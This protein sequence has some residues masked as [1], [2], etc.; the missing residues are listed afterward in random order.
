ML[1]IEGF[2]NKTKLDELNQVLDQVKFIPG[3]RSGGNAGVLI[4]NNLQHDP[5]DPNYPRAAGLVF[6]AI[7]A[8]PAFHAYSFANKLTPVIF[9][10]YSPGMTYGDHVDSAIHPLSNLVVR[11]DLSMT[12]FLAEPDTYDG[13]ELVINVMGAEKTVKGK[14]GD[15]FLYPTGVT[16]R[17]NAV[18]SGVRRAAVAWVQSLIA[19]HEHREIVYKL[20]RAR[21]GILA[22]AGRTPE[23]ELV[24]SAC[25]NLLRM[26]S[27]P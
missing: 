1:L 10:R 4:K 18:R 20:Q 24:N 11:T 12:L 9:S 19:D 23:F 17:V 14:A 15:L 2:L 27:Q 25:E 3:Q 8:S 26:F 16:H 6:N 22:S 21:D 13:G 7:Q 5:S